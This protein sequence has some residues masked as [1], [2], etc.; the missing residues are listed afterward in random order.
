MQA[1][2][3]AADITPPVGAALN[4]FIARSGASTGIDTRLEA[5]CLCLASGEQQVLLVSLDLLGLDAGTADGLVTGTADRLGIPPDNVV[6]SCTHTH[7]GPMTVRLRGLGPADERYLEWICERVIAASAD[8]AEKLR[9]VRSR[10]GRAPLQIGCNRRRRIDTPDGPSIVLG[11]NPEGPCDAEVRVL[12]LQGEASSIVLVHHACHPYGLGGD[13]TLLSADFW[14]HAASALRDAGHLPTFLNGCAGNIAPVDGFGGVAAARRSGRSLAAAV[15][16][17][18]AAG[19]DARNEE[20]RVCS[21]RVSVPYDRLPSIQSIRAELSRPDRTV[22]DVERGDADVQRRIRAAWHEWLC[23][24][25]AATRDGRE[26]APVEGRVSVVRIGDGAVVALPGEVFF[27]TGRDI[28]ARLDA[29]P[30]CVGAYCHG[31]IGYVPT[32]GAFS[33]GGYEVEEA[34]RYLGLWRVGPAACGILEQETL[35][36]WR[37]TGGAVR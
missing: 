18:V 37:R 19:Q 20:L 24:L 22:R 28:A 29:N 25:D 1:G 35:K 27:E 21:Q 23:E 32:P 10:W 26:L 9:P 31:Y 3:S 14:G 4:G 2:F 34:H 12:H 5:R 16:A 13:A 36:L 11:S 15:L 33:E 17:A 8:A 6:V 30:V 7:S